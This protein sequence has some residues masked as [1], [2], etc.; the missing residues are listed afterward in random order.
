MEGQSDLRADY[1][2]DKVLQYRG[3]TRLDTFRKTRKRDVVYTRFLCIYFIK[4]YTSPLN[5]IIPPPKLS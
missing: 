1:I 5:K 2:V 3:M 4:K